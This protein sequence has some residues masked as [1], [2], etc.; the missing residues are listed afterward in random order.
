MK[1][2]YQFI[3][4]EMARDDAFISRGIEA[5][6]SFGLRANKGTW[7]GARSKFSDILMGQT[8]IT[9]AAKGSESNQG[10]YY[11]GVDMGK[12]KK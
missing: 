10:E 8:G 9:Q 11:E 1:W 3:E 2:K 6:I 5:F 12:C 7:N 4:H